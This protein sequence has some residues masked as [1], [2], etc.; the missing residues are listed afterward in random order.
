M[1]DLLLW[2]GGIAAAITAVIIAAQKIARVLT[3][4]THGLLDWH[5]ARVASE[6]RAALEPELT[7][8]HHELRVNGGAS[9]K[10]ATNR[11]DRNVAHLTSKVN[12]F[13]E[14]QRGKNHDLLN[15]IGATAGLIQ[16]LHADDLEKF[17]GRLL[18]RLEQIAEHD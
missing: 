1:S 4:V 18:D 10:D 12:E 5:L 9:V 15:K 14:Y 3:D 17:G 11:L 13:A 16:L 6:V 8:I 2:A 7:T